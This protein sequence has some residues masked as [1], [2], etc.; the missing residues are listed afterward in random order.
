[1]KKLGLYL[2]FITSVGLLNAQ[3]QDNTIAIGDVLVLSQ[4]SSSSYQYI[5]FPKPNIII[6]RGAIATFNNLIGKKLIVIEIITT[7]DGSKDV[8]LTRKDG[9]NFF[10]FFPKVTSNLDKALANKELKT[11]KKENIIAQH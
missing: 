4:P 3:E 1:M 6:K 9:R 10:R 11:L 7:E 2:A 8:V 5:D